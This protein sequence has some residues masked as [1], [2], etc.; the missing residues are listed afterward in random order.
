MPKA[1]WSAFLSLILVFLSGALVGVVGYRL[2]LVNTVQGLGPDSR[3]GGR[4]DPEQVRRQRINEMREAVKL[5][6]QQV[7]EIEQVYDDT[8]A[9]FEQSRSQFDQANKA[10][11]EHQAQRIRSLLRPDQVPL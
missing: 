7:K 3:R 6:D 2:Y 4:P 8:H 11:G 9:Q 10:I 5:D 1:K